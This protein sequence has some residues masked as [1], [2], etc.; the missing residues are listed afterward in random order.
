MK[1]ILVDSS[2][3]V[4]RR[5][6]SRQRSMICLEELIDRVLVAVGE[7]GD[8]AAHFPPDPADEPRRRQVL[9]VLRA[10]RRTGCAGRSRRNPGGRARSAR[11]SCGSARRASCFSRGSGSTLRFDVTSVAGVR[12][13]ASAD[14]CTRASAAPASRRSASPTSTADRATR[15]TFRRSLRPDGSARTSD[16]GA[17]RSSCCTAWACS[18]RDTAID[19]RAEQ[20]PPRRASPQPV[21]VVDGVAR[22]RAAGSAGTTRRRRLRLPASARAR[23][24]PA[25]DAPG[26]TE[27]RCRGRRRA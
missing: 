25:A 1:S 24:S 9:R 7:A 17:G 23:A 14:P 16:R 15:R 2:E 13:R 6:S 11:A 10:R 4:S 20:A 5:F 26:R 27:S 12:A 8:R 21:R 18:T 22:L 19:G 3:S